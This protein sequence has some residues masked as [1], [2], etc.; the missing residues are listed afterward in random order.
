MKL[1]SSSYTKI[2]EDATY[3]SNYELKLSLIKKSNF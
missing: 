1:N 2:E 3:R